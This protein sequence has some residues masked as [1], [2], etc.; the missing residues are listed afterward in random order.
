MS[1]SLKNNSKSLLRKKLKIKI[2]AISKTQKRQ[3]SLTVC[4]GLWLSDFIQ[5]AERVLVY[6][7]RVDELDTLPLIRRLLK[8]KKKVYLPRIEN[9]RVFLY[10]I[11]NLKTDL[12]LGAY[13]IRE[14][15][16]T[17]ARQCNVRQMDLA[18]VPGLGFT[19]DGV[20]LGRGGGHFDRLLAKAGHVVKIGVGFREQILK[21]IPALRH[22][23]RMNFVVTD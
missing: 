20:R 16:K 9:D 15:K 12:E 1:P 18:I 3:K 2:A 5:E 4:K 14:P 7:G 22:D 19:H 17:K 10:R 23:V 6:A 21:K 11:T 13:G 8:S